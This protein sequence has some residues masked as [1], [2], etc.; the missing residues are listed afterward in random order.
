MKDNNRINKE[1][2]DAKLEKV[3]G[4]YFGPTETYE[5][6]QERC[7]GCGA[8]ECECPSI[9]IVRSDDGFSFRINQED[10]VYCGRCY[11]I[12]PINAVVMHVIEE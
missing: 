7:A 6:I 10:C 2:E 12:C 5:I 9:A 4:G 1:V 11:Q 8:C 3:T